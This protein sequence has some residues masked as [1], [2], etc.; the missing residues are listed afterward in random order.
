MG[1]RWLMQVLHRSFEKINLNARK[2]TL[3]LAELF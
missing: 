3:V 1:F 2:V